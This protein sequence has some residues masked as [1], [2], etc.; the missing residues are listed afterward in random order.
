MM[1]SPN[2]EGRMS[3][4]DPNSGRKLVMENPNTFGG[5][6]PKKNNTV[7]IAAI[8]IVLLLCCCCIL[9]IC[10]WWLWNNGDA[11]MDMSLLA[12]LL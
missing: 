4:E 2:P 9:G 1:E 11:L 3:I 8:V 7:L 5:P 6:E 12:R 10:G